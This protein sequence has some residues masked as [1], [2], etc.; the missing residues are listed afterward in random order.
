[1]SSSV[2]LVEK[3]ESLAEVLHFMKKNPIRFLAQIDFWDWEMENLMFS[4]SNFSERSKAWGD[5][6]TVH[7]KLKSLGIVLSRDANWYLQWNPIYASMKNVEVPKAKLLEVI[8]MWNALIH[9]CESHFLGDK[10]K[11]KLREKYGYNSTL[12][13]YVKKLEKEK[14]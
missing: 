14:S 12:E 11:P 5:E 3:C 2:Y 6:D 4:F 7:E 9:Y 10:L 8:S 13:K 1:M